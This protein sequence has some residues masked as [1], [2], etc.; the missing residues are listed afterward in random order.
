MLD[1]AIYKTRRGLG[2]RRECGCR[3]GLRTNRAGVSIA[4][5]SIEPGPLQ[6]LYE[7]MI[8]DR[9]QFDFGS[10][11]ANVTKQRQSLLTYVRWYSPS[12]AVDNEPLVVD[13]TEITARQHIRRLRH[14]ADPKRF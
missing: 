3:L 11:Q 7:S 13:S 2:P 4:D 10:R 6:P 8:P 9:V 1:K 14:N 5:I 12:S